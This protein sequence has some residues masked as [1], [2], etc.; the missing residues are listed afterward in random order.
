MTAI[1]EGHD[2]RQ[3]VDLAISAARKLE[4]AQT[5]LIHYPTQ[6]TIPFYQN[7]CFCLALFRSLVGDNVQEAKERL[8]HL[9]FF[10]DENGLFPTYMHEYPKTCPYARSSFP[11]KLIEKHFGHIL[12]SEIRTKLKAVAPFPLPP[13]EILSSKDAGVAALHLEDLAPLTSYW[14]PELNIYN[15]PLNDERQNEGEIELTLFDLFMGNSPRILKPHPVHIEAALVFSPR[16]VEFSNA[17]HSAT[18]PHGKGYHLLRKVWNEGDHLHTLVCQEKKMTLEGDILIYPEEIPDEK[19]RTELSF[20]VNYHP[21][22]TI[23]INKEKGTVFRLGDVVQI[24]DNWK[25]SFE[26]IDGEGDFLGHISRGNRPAQL[27][28]DITQAHDR[29]ISIRT[30]RRSKNLKLRLVLQQD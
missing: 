19:N 26:K 11:L 15:G 28:T 30:L 16:P 25:L 7:F 21:S 27:D 3:L 6:D 23:L 1:Q 29:K 5:G 10:M 4:S 22:N 2:R 8:N 20:F 17:H 9:L 12:G 14:D 13:K 18:I 24:G